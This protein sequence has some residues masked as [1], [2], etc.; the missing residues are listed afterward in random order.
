MSMLDILR[1]PA[2]IAHGVFK[3]VEAEVLFHRRL[4]PDE[5]GYSTKQYASA[6]K[7][8]A[9]V[10]LKQRM[11]NT[12]TGVLAPSSVTII[13]LDVPALSAAT[14]GLGISVHDRIVI[15]PNKVQPIVNVG[16]FLDRGTKLPVATEAYLG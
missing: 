5:D 3:D 9:I 11:V 13:F 10:E 16:G 15:S 6:V 14:K 1:L 12:P 2:K 4:Q 7:L 8:T